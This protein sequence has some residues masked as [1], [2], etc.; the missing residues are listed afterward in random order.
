VARRVDDWLLGRDAELAVL[1]RAIQ[2]ARDNGAVLLIEGEAGIGKSALMRAVSEEAAGAGFAVTACRPAEAEAG[3]AYAALGDLVSDLLDELGDDLPRPQRYA[4]ARALHRE[5][6]PDRVADDADDAGADQPT[7]PGAVAAATTT[8]LRAAAGRAL[9]CVVVDDAQWLDFP[10]EQALR[11]AVRRLAQPG[12]LVAVARRLKGPGDADPLGLRAAFPDGRL[13][14]V[15]PGGLS[16]GA[17]HALI[18]RELGLS[19]SRMRL[20]ELHSVTR[21]NP[22]FGLEIGRALARRH[23][24][25]APGEP[26][27]VPGSLSQLLSARIVGASA[28]A[29]EVLEIVAVADRPTAA[30]LEALFGSAERAQE[31]RDTAMT[32][33]LVEMDG[34][35]IRPIHPLLAS[36][37]VA[38]MPAARRRHLHRQL[39]EVE[40]EPEARARHLAFATPGEHAEVS[41]ALE[42]AAAVAQG[43]GAV[44]TA[45]EL[46]GMAAER[47]PHADSDDMRRRRLLLGAALLDAGELLRAGTV[48]DELLA[49]EL[50]ADCRGEVAL[51]R[52]TVAWYLEPSPVAVRY[53]TE[54]LAAGVA[55]VGLAGRLHMHLAIFYDY[56]LEQGREH[57]TEAVRLLEA[58]FTADRSLAGALATALCQLFYCEVLLGMSPREDLLERALGIEPHAVKADRSTTPGMWWAATD[59]LDEA[60]AR[61]AAQLQLSRETGDLSGEADLL[62]RL[63]EVA[64]WQEDWTEA[65][66]LADE[67]VAAFRQEGRAVPEPALRV[68]AWVDA[69][70]GDLDRA[71]AAA[72][73]A[74]SRVEPSEGSNLAA[75]WLVVAVLVAATRGDA[76]R[77]AELTARSAAHLAAIG[78][79]EG[80]RLDLSG[81]RVAALCQLGDFDEASALLDQLVVRHERVPRY[82][83]AAAVARGRALL[84]HGRGRTSDAIAAIDAAVGADRWP[85]IERARTLLLRGQLQRRERDRRG[86]R[87]SLEAAL[88]TFEVLGARAWQEQAEAELRRLGHHR[89]GGVELTPTE[90]E[91]ALLAAAGLSTREV[92][93]RL[94]VSPKTVETHLTHI[95][96]KL[97]ISSRAQLGA[98][99]GGASR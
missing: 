11:F 6:A 73:D 48:A 99:M 26:L 19:L 8:L 71:E 7:T 43:R 35:R 56:D 96:G 40:E 45:A 27:P 77:V 65:A 17:L 93:A 34:S 64:L 21:G 46:L 15:E 50:D 32:D 9:L 66:A 14:A 41:A 36:A 39:A 88:A 61:F 59:R 79:Q 72:A 37:A 54:A 1:R 83:L 29:R 44:E 92:A 80:L 69:C 30:T 84:A 98:R 4:L 28:A 20:L 76:A 18:H 74:A 52:A 23:E 91:V 75:A 13:I 67:A 94:F 60:R 63:A 47:T 38:A 55:D 97:G 82:P 87:E 3:Y 62:T 16:T 42:A 25:L 58:G 81:E 10:T 57:G 78:I 2:S 53:L 22:L 51:V 95:Y 31:C 86:A 90:R 24:Q 5:V 85:G 70:R 68:R 89:P 49:S 12:I 33:H